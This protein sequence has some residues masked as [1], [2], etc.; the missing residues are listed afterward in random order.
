MRMMQTQR[1]QRHINYKNKVN[2]WAVLDRQLEQYKNLVSEIEKPIDRFF[3]D[4]MKGSGD[5][6]THIDIFT[7]FK[8]ILQKYKE[9]K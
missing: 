1:V 5:F 3:N 8:E 2:D 7:E 6:P 9:S 4:T